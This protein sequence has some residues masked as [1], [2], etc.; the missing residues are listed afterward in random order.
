M[1]ERPE[2]DLVG[3]YSYY[4]VQLLT[5]SFYAPLSPVV[6]PALAF[7]FIVQYFIDKL[8]LFNRS[9]IP[10]K[11]SFRMTDCTL[12]LAECSLLSFLVGWILFCPVNLW[13]PLMEAIS[14]FCLFIT[15][16]FLAY[17]FRMQFKNK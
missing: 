6:V 4:I 14:Y 17:R 5:V 12:F 7:I 13:S 16:L 8:I 1:I 15:I 9:S 11:V 10:V 2:F 3:K